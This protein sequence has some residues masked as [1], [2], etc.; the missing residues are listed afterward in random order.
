MAEV[1]EVA[2]EDLVDAC[3]VSAGQE[4]LDVGAGDGNFAV[5]AAFE[6]ARVV[7]SDITPAM[8][9]LGRARSEAQGLGVE[10]VEADV[11][12]LP[13]ADASFDCVGSVFGAVFAPRPELVASEPFRV[14]RPGGTVGLTAWPPESHTGRF[15]ML[16]AKYLPMP[17]GV[18]PSTDWGREEI[19]RSRFEGL[20][21]SLEFRRGAVEWRFASREGMLDFLEQNAPPVVAARKGMPPDVYER[22]RADVIDMTDGFNKAQDGSVEIDAEYLLILARKRG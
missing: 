17:E 21:A 20:A 3:A 8:V 18:P 13:F 11:E 5:L 16:S 15:S 22:V 6:G 14:V 9:E 2:A 19:V 1:L 10:W 12:E 4:V 7:A